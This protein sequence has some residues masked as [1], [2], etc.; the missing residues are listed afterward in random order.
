M[1]TI[2]A[3]IRIADQIKIEW[4]SD[5]TSP[6]GK[7]LPTQEELAERF[8]VSRAT[9][10]RTLSRLA[11][12]GYIHSQQGSGVYIAERLPRETA[13]QCLSLVVPQ[14]NATV[15]VQACRG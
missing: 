15:I 8:G 11:A 9:I 5:P 6:E 2:P 14:I 13:T 10:V 1:G 4:L 12:E 7:K 3:Y